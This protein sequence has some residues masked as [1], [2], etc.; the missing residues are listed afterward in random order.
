MQID[1]YKLQIK[2]ARPP[3][4]NLHFA[5]CNLQ[6]RRSLISLVIGT[7]WFASSA[8]PADRP[9]IL[10]IM[11][12]DH[13][14]QAVSAYGG[15]LNRTTSIDRIAS[16]GMRFDRC[17][18]T[19]SL[20]GPSR[21]CILT[22]KY[23]HKN[24]FFDNTSGKFDG[25]QTTFP[26]LL[27]KAGYQTAVVG[28]WHLVSDPTGFD[29][30]DILPGQG[31]YYRP[32]FISAAGRR[33]VSGYVTDVTTDLALDWLK[34]DRDTEKPF[35]LMVHYKAPHRPW[36]PAREKLA[37]REQEKIPE[38][39]TLFDDYATR[40]RAAHEAHMRINQMRP[41]S[42]VKLWETN[43]PERKFL[44]NRMSSADRAA[45]EKHVDPRL[46]Q[47]QA[48]NPEGDERTRWFYQLYLKDYLRCV[49]SVDESVGKLLD[50]LDASGLA[51][52]TIVVYTSDQGFYLGEHGWFD[53]RFMYEQ[54]LR[55]PLVIRWPSVVKPSSV[56][57]RIASN[58]DF[59]ETFLEAAGAP[60]PGDMQGRS[61]VPLLRGE[62]PDNWRRA[63]YYHF[64][65]DK[66]AD[67]RVAKHEGVTNG[68]AKLIHFYT[69]GEW[70]MYDLESDP[71]ELINIYGKPDYAELQQSL[72]T[73]LER[74][75]RELEVPPNEK[76]DSRKGVK[77]QRNQELPQRT[78]R[79]QR[80]T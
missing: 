51:D 24:G 22:G 32:D 5:I 43:S 29:H 72:H 59:A 50:H 1:H 15:N 71:H 20:C 25:S 6:F 47:F 11:S 18:V 77:A 27:Q 30:W 48:A 7:L 58:V 21:A 56:Q 46:D 10:F 12:D 75:R 45:W 3:I 73:E 23:S 44:F 60:I 65:E 35:L 78:R 70:E 68:R 66:D 57:D 40:G 41:E 55:T 63:F 39:A 9:N 37:H 53:K 76:V 33:D 19:N 31:Q 64:Y 4:C 42:D 49:E 2:G 16:E 79:A 13:A 74:L 61:L 52:N 38:P 36:H 69:L 54:S 80:Q 8:L 67:H 17:Y 14:Y 26:K 28:K 34:N 62:K